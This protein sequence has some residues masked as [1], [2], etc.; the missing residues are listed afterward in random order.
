MRL[1]EALLIFANLLTFL[2]MAIPR[3]RAIPWVGYI[4]FVALF[5]AVIQ[6]LVEGPRWQVVPAY[7]LTAFF[8]LVWLLQNVVSVSGIVGQILTNRFVVGFVIILGVIGIVISVVIPN[9]L[10]VFHFPRP[11]GP[12]SIGTITYHWTDVSR[13]EVFSPDKN[14]YRELM[15]QVWYPAKKSPSSSY[16]RYIQDPDAVTTALAK[17]HHFPDSSLSYLKYVTTN[18]IESAPIA[19]DSPNYPVL[20][21]LEGLTGFRQMSTFQIEE[22]VSHGYIVVGLDQPGVAASV[23][24]PDGHQIAIVGLFS[25]IQSLIQQST[26]PVETAP[27]FN[28]QT[29]EDGIIPYFAQDVSFTLDQLASI[30]QSDPRHILTEKLDLQHIGVFGMSL[31]GMVG[32]EACLKDLRIKSC[33][34]MDVEMTADVV[35]R[36]LQQ[37]CMWITR[38]ADTMRLE[39]QKA[40]GWAE[41]DIVR[42][43]NTMRSVYESL[44]GDGYFIQVPG[45]FHIDLTDLDLLSP[46]FP[47]IGFSGPI[48]SQRAH[49][50]ANAYSV[51]FFDKYLKGR[52]GDTLDRLVA[53]YPE[54]IFEKRQS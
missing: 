43:Q 42:T 28:G 5:I 49:D 50:I 41:K 20:I 17:L 15:A 38:P 19:D 33:L 45:M 6:I 9:V 14:A 13:H 37:P 18:A 27:Q 29:F 24:F 51:A 46:F 23:A 25:Q 52:S 21:F 31:G 12:Y 47:N 11:G 26:D 35:Q 34:I 2:V 10:P 48:G 1:V 54:T 32:G 40:G 44:P 16:A 39:R 36:G 3:F 30:N 53:H 8:S 22:L 4:V 7:V